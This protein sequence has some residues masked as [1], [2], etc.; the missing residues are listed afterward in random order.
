MARQ[1]V[2][3]NSSTESNDIAGNAKC[4]NDIVVSMSQKDLK[5]VNN[6]DRGDENGGVLGSC[7]MVENAT[8]CSN[9][10]PLC[11]SRRILLKSFSAPK[12]H[13]F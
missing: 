4:G 11:D 8:N 10:T 7:D 9:V 6:N 12:C 1:L 13:E 2:S 5:H 3:L